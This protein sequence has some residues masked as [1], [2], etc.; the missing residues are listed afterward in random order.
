MRALGANYFT[1]ASIF[2]F[3]SDLKPLFWKQHRN[4]DTLREAAARALSATK[5]LINKNVHRLLAGGIS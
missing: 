4:F 5:L 3:T 1:T 2:H